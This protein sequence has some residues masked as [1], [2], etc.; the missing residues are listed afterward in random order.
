MAVIAAL[1]DEHEVEKII[2]GHPRRLDGTVGGQA[3]QVEAYASQLQEVVGVPVVLWDEA[4]STARAQEA[5]IEAGRKRQ[6]RKRRIDAV[7]AAVI[8]QEYLNSLGSRDG[9]RDSWK[10]KTF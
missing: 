3:R 6:D 9:R 2:V 10:E 7:A 1:V 8:L 5:M 4:F